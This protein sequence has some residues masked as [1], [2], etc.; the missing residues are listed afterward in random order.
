MLICILSCLSVPYKQ[1]NYVKQFDEPGNSDSITI[2]ANEFNDFMNDYERSKTDAEK[3]RHASAVSLLKEFDNIERQL[4]TAKEENEQQRK[5]I[6]EV[7]EQSEIKL[8]KE[9]EKAVQDAAAKDTESKRQLE[10]KEKELSALRAELAEARQKV[11]EDNEKAVQD[12]A[13]KDTESKRQLEEK[14]KELS[15]LRAELATA[16]QKVKEGSDKALPL[17]TDK[18]RQHIPTENRASISAKEIDTHQRSPHKIVRNSVPV[19]PSRGTRSLVVLPANEQKVVKE[20]VF[21]NQ[22]VV[23]EELMY[24]RLVDRLGKELDAEREKTKELRTQRDF[25]QRKSCDLQRALG[26]LL[27]LEEERKKAGEQ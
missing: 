25:L 3:Q 23:H 22:Y 5:E 1:M 24:A 19:S 18:N 27:K 11:K 9:Q 8:K 21:V 10:E 13:A 14:E 17:D 12:A 2:D 26:K 16:R 7:K 20:K 4:A 15:A 6:D